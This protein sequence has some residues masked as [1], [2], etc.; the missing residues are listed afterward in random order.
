MLGAGCPCGFGSTIGQ[1]AACMRGV[2]ITYFHLLVAATKEQ[3][4]VVTGQHIY[5]CQKSQASPDAL[6]AADV[7]LQKAHI[8]T[9]NQSAN[10]HGTFAAA[11]CRLKVEQHRVPPSH[12]T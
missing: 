4:S 7:E 6:Y 3:F 5:S 12:C 11:H 1:F 9:P 8:S 2:C 10:R